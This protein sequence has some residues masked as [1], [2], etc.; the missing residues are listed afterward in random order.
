MMDIRYVTTYVDSSA[1][2]HVSV[3]LNAPS[4]VQSHHHQLYLFVQGDAGEPGLKGFKGDPGEDGDDATGSS[5]LVVT[6]YTKWGANDCP[7]GTTTVYS[8]TAGASYFN[9]AG[10]GSNLVCLHPSYSFGLFTEDFRSSTFGSVV[11][12]E[13]RTSANDPLVSL[14]EQN[15]PCAVCAVMSDGVYMQPGKTTCEPGWTVQYTGYI[16][17]EQEG[18]MIGRSGERYRGEFVCVMT[19]P[20]VIPGLQTPTMEAELSHVHVDCPDTEIL[21]CDDYTAALACVVCSKV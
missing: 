17:S 4:N 19:S 10:A 8:G 20:D 15:V 6:C 21:D 18:T 9:N 3:F 1:A 11:G 13:Y 2:K 14:N 12:V 7:D 16:M 5:N